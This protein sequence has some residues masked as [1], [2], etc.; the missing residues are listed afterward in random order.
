MW[1]KFLFTLI[2]ILGVTISTDETNT[3]FKGNN[4]DQT[5]MT[6]KAEGDVL[7]ANALCN[8]G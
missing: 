7:E 4:S 3:H 1:M 6:Y 5:R 8:E 2:L